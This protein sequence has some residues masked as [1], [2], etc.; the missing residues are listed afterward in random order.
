MKS[1]IEK[2]EKEIMYYKI[3]FIIQKFV[4]NEKVM[5]GWPMDNWKVC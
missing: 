3:K 4:E 5:K 1:L 2:D